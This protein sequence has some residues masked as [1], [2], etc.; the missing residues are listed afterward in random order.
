[1]PYLY[2][3]CGFELDTHV[4][5]I[6][7]TTTNTTSPEPVAEPT[8]LTAIM[9]ELSSRVPVMLVTKQGKQNKTSITQPAGNEFGNTCLGNH[10]QQTLHAHMLPTTSKTTLPAPPVPNKPPTASAIPTQGPNTMV[11]ALGSSRGDGVTT[12]AT[13]TLTMP[14]TMTMTMAATTTTNSESATMAATTAMVVMW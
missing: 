5:Q 4:H 1:M 7:A 14:M 13:T 9:S 3:L 6:I 8:V 10:Q 2:P 11:A 12:T